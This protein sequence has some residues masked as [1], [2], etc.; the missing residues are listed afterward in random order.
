MLIR[1]VLGAVIGSFG[2]H[3]AIN[4]VTGADIVTSKEQNA[5][6]VLICVRS[7]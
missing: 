2:G 5:V 7:S 1:L 4:P 6:K 3:T